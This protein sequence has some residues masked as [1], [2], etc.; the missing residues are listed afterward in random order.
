[1][2][3]SLTEREIKPAGP[4]FGLEISSVAYPKDRAK[5]RIR[6][7]AHYT[8]G[9]CDLP[10]ICF[11]EPK[12]DFSRV[13]G[14]YSNG[15]II[16]LPDLVGG[17]MTIRLCP[18]PPMSGWETPAERRALEKNFTLKG[19]AIDF[20]E[21]HHLDIWV[22]NPDNNVKIEAITEQPVKP[23]DECR[24]YLYSFP[25]TLDALTATFKP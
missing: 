24:E 11:S 18:S 9:N 13:P 19:L 1:M 21:S 2:S 10:S 15:A 16:S 6:D 17:Q 23:G 3:F 22:G 4:S 5:R 14:R 8:G 7:S 20:G 12:V 25:K